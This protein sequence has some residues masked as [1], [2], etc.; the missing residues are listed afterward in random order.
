MKKL[1][2]GA[3]VVIVLAGVYWLARPLFTDVEV[4]EPV[5]GISE[6]A[7]TGDS[8]IILAEGR[9]ADADSFHQGEGV[10]RLINV[11]GKNFIRFEDDFK[12]T[13]GPDLFVYFGSNGVYA[14]EAKIGAL[15]GNKGSQNYEVPDGIDIEKYNEVWVWCRAFSVPFAHAILIK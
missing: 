10:V 4:Y 13:N 3:G 1:F 5:L 8:Q 15:K 7:S 12:V 2:I 11:A 6:T 9:F 14:K